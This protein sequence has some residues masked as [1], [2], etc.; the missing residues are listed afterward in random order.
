MGLGLDGWNERWMNGIK[1]QRK[2]MMD[3]W[4]DGKNVRCL[5]ERKWIEEGFR[6]AHVM[7]SLHVS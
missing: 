7:N 3:G 5:D 2:G 1:V 4:I 6:T